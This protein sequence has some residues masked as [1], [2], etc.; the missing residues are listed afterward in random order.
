MHLQAASWSIGAHGRVKPGL[1]QKDTSVIVWTRT[2]QSKSY[3]TARTAV[4]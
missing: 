2:H 4:N 1:D 3:E